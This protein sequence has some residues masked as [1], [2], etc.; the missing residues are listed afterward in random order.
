MNDPA[1]AWSLLLT[2]R[3]YPSHWRFV[4]ATNVSDFRTATERRGHWFQNTKTGQDMIIVDSLPTEREL[5]IHAG[6]VGGQP[7]QPSPRRTPPLHQTPIL[8]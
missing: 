8:E 7:R 2:A 3:I 5:K 4:G 1:K 6:S